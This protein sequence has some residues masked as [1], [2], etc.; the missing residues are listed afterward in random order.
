MSYVGLNPQQQLLNTSTQTFSGNAVAYQFTL[1][2]AV[3][4]ASDLDVMIDQTL[5]RPFADYE[6]ENVSLLFQ[7][8]PPSGTNNITVTYRAG[9]L[10]SLNLTANAFGAGTVGAPSVYSVAANNT[11]IYWPNATTMVMTVAGGN[12]AT[13]SSNVASTS[14]VTGAL[15]VTG[16]MGVTG[17]VNTSGAVTITDT[18]NSGNVTTG[19]LTVSGGAGIVGNLNIGGDITCV[20]DFTVNGTFTT[21]G[22]D[23]LEVNDPFIFLANANPGDTFDSGVIT[24]YFDGVNTRYSGYFRDITDAKY[25]LFGNLIVKPTTV[26][27]TANASFTYNDLI[28]ANLSATGNVSGTYILGNGALL[29]GITTETSQIFNGNSR[30]I[31]PS[32]A[33]NIVNNVNG[34]TVATVWSGGLVVTGA[35]SGSTTLLVTGNVTG[36]NITTAG[37]ITGT[38]N[39]TSAANVSAGNI[40]TGGLISAAGNIGGANVNTGGLILAT[41]NIT[42]GNVNTAGQA[43]AGGN[44]TGGNVRTAGSVSAAGVVYGDSFSATLGV[45]AG[46]T[47]AATT[48]ITAGGTISAVGTI[49]GDGGV[50]SSANI[51]GGNITTGG[52]VSATGNV[53][54]GNIT[55]AGQLVSSKLGSSAANAGQIFLNGVGNNRIDFNTAGTDPPAYT[56]RSAGTKITLFPSVSATNADY[57]IGIDVSTL[58][59]SVPGDDGSQFF[60]W[61]GGTTLVGSLSS[62]G[63]LSVV[64]NVIGG[65]IN[66]GGIVSSTGN[67]VGGN[68]IAATLV[69]STSVSAT[70]NVTG[71]NILTGGIASATGNVTGGNIITSGAI[72]AGGAV[73]ATGNVVGG[74][75]SAATAITAGSG[76]VSATG[77]V[78]GG[79]I[80]T[81]GLTTSTGNITSAGNIAGGNILGTTLV[82]GSIVSATANVLAAAN[83]SAA[84]TVLASQLSLSGNIISAIATTSNITGANVNATASISAGGNITGGNI[85]TAGNLSIPTAAQNTNTTQAATTA[86]VIGQASSTTPG[87]VGSAA[88]GTGTTFARADHTHSGVTNIT[89]SSGLSTNTNATGAVSITNTGVISAAAGTG[90][91]VSGATGAVTFSIGQAV[92]TNSGVTFASLTVGTGNLS[93]GNINNNNVTGVGNIGTSTVG[94]N[95]VF[96]KATSAQYADLA[97]NYA[98]DAVYAPGTVLVFGG[99]NE[100]TVATT[101][102]DPKVAGVVSTNPAHLMNSVMEA[103]H[104]VAVA[105]TGRVPAQVIGPVK[106]GDMMVSSINGRAQACATPAMGTVIGKA[107]QDFDGDQGTIEIVVGRL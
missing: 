22:T 76:G 13:F 53:I 11:G 69:Q 18:T 35:I 14:N 106:K 55:T 42:G 103:D 19:A 10:N 62:T 101:V 102:S 28:L 25:K 73:S 5:Q 31:I 88:V 17:N 56:T 24:E 33:G 26:V 34:V 46:T 29:S 98:A 20:G 49:T 82:Q 45:S 61:Y 15:T 68:V 70:G 95:T 50:T 97:E 90:V 85:S 4:S 74:N 21:T 84:G 67:V 78:T 81:A 6:A 65:N 27:D 48:D 100:V 91:S 87:A 41:G 72:S 77:N 1:G 40:T 86:F 89:T 9:A 38:G 12:R 99:S 43:S 7:T 60:K 79:N 2:R 75:V 32:A 54:G 16:G 71:G 36:G 92:A 3:A 47:V 107:L 51:A 83:I 23:S 104:I 57:A 30:V 66:T 80:V 59:N 105:L 63:I 93:G 37:Q 44:I 94:F 96:A 58:W 64:G 52:S 39:I 8:P